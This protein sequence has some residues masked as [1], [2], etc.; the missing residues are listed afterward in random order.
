MED[1]AAAAD[2]ADWWWRCCVVCSAWLLYHLIAISIVYGIIAIDRLDVKVWDCC[3]TP[4]NPKSK[5]REVREK[6]AAG[7]EINRRSKPTAHV[8]R[9]PRRCV[10][11]F[12]EEILTMM[13]KLCLSIYG[14]VAAAV[15]GSLVILPTGS[16]V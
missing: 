2:V 9:V 11:A 15:A 8:H 4:K 16:N 14:V 12:C 3:A 6:T 13:K 7:P 1:D 10:F 5:E